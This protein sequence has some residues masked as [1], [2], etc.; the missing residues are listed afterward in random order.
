MVG[1][2]TAV[3]AVVVRLEQDVSLDGAVPG[4]VRSGRGGMVC[5]TL[6]VAASLGA[7]VDGVVA[8]GGDHAG[9]ALREII[10][11]EGIDASFIETSIS[12]TTV[13]LSSGVTRSSIMG[14]EG[15]REQHLRRVGSL[16]F[17]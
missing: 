8:C 11:L 17:S 12:P 7:R 1:L 13:T 16:A 15:E 14:K 2:A 4:Q 5:N 10:T 9:K 6:A 3:S